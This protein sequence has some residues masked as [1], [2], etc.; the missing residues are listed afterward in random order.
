MFLLIIWL[1]EYQEKVS[2]KYISPIHFKL[3]I[4]K[5]IGKDAITHFLKLFE[6]LTLK[7]LQIIDNDLNNFWVINLYF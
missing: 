7:R 2:I 4:Q 5:S 3:I 1:K 6:N